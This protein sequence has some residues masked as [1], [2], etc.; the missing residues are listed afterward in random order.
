M[1]LQGL[2]ESH[3]WLVVLLNQKAGLER[4]WMFKVV[5]ICRGKGGLPGDRQSP[6][7]LITAL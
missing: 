2:L 6:S 3:C 7:H 5:N 4:P 1:A